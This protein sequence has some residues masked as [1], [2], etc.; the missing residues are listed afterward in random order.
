MLFLSRN[1][2]KMPLR[3][4][5]LPIFSYLIFGEINKRICRFFALFCRKPHINASKLNMIQKFRTIK[6]IKIS[7]NFDKF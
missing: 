3:L 7:D 1:R 6:S 2:E 4:I 5:I